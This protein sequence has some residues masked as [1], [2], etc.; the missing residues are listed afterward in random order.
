[1]S[2][3]AVEPATDRE[4]SNTS[5]IVEEKK[6]TPVPTVD[7]SLKAQFCVIGCVS[8]LGWN[9]I[10]GELGTLIDAFG[11]SYGTWVSMFYSLFINI[12][13]LM[14]VYVGN[15]FKFGP[16]FY[17][18]CV[19]MGVSMMVIA[20]CAITFA[21]AN[22]VAGF[23]CGC[24]LIAIFGFSNALMESSM[25]GLAALV[26]ADCTKWIMVGEGFAGLLAWPVNK[27]CQVI[28]E[29]CGADDPSDMMYI[30][31]V[32]F[33]FVGMIG[34]LAIIPMYKYA[35]EPHPY[36]I[37]VLK[38]QQDRVKFQLKKTMKRPVGQVIKDSLP[39]AFNVW[40]NFTITF[41]TFPWLIFEMTPSS[42]SVGSFGQ[43]MTYCF[44]VFDTLGRFSPNLHVKL[45]KRATRYVCIGRL[46]FIPLMFLCVHIAATPFDDD[47]F[48]FIVMAL[49]SAT[50]GCVATWCMIHGPSQVD[51]EE[52]EE[53]EIAGYVMA[54]AL[55]F[56][57][58][59]GSIIAIIIQQSAY[60]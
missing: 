25:F 30:R 37:D 53:L 51:Q 20:V 52:K 6:T 35:M 55:V 40:L 54:F 28:V 47:W 44:Q 33:Y 16:R 38:I 34:N 10:L 14:L 36:M 7:W 13:Q 9:F 39:Q 5:D 23:V 32:V 41:T 12:G 50:N 22:H 21:R 56:G 18:G 27:L 57:I 46:I 2:S 1:M 24:L 42:L 3:P 11:A 8:L 43:L 31:M 26:T 17:I 45:G 15:R 48:R 59:S 58:F 49:L 4:V 60:I 29:A 19:G